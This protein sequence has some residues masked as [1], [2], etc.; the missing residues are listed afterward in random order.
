MSLSSFPDTFGLWELKKG[1][2][3]HLFNTS[4]NQEYSGP[5]P[6]AEYYMLN[7]MTPSTRQEFDRWYSKQVAHQ[8]STGDL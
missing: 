6:V 5:L 8:E 7:G 4:A 1:L 3:P 2:F